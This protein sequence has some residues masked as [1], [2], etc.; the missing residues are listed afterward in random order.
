MIARVALLMLVPALLPAQSPRAPLDSL[1][2]AT[3]RASARF[4]DR[5][6]ASGEGYRRIGPDFPAMGEHW[7]NAGMLLANTLDPARPTLLTYATIAGRPR[8]LGVG[9]VVTIGGAGDG[10]APRRLPG[11][12]DEWHEHSGLLGDESGLAPSVARSDRTR[13]WV[14]HVWTGL[15]NPDGA[16]APD[17]WSLPYARLRITPPDSVDL[18]A[19]RA[20]ALAAGGDDYWR[21]LLTDARLRTDERAAA[22]D[23]ALASA[24]SRVLAR[25][26]AS[27]ARSLDLAAVGR[28]WRSL[29]ASLRTLLG[30]DVERYL[31]PSHSRPS[32]ADPRAAHH[33]MHLER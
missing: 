27:G 9:F 33:H 28:E 21:D 17:N 30:P 11:W 19:A 12:P 2:G 15:A 16:Y 4:A 6:V 24:R 23:A 8:L 18:D 25:V 1:A 13:V 22:V 29:T 14:L 7:L 32:A 20:L 10:S 26:P 31:A 5:R 3:A